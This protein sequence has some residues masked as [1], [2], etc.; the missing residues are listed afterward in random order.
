MNLAHHKALIT[1]ASK[2]LGKAIALQLAERGC[3]VTLLAR[4]EKLLRQT[5]HE[6]PLVNKTQNHQYLEYDLINLIKDDPIPELVEQ[7]EDTTI[8]VNCAGMTTH[9]LLHRLS[10]L[11]VLDTFNTNLISPVLLSQ[12]A[13]KPMLKNSK[14][15]DIKP[16]IVNISSV[17]SFTDFTS[18]GTTAYSATKAGLLGFT[19][20]LALE[21]RGRVRVNSILPGLIVETEMGQNSKLDVKPV[22]LARV[23][24]K[25]VE[26]IGDDSNGRCII[27]A[28][29]ISFYDEA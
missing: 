25:V 13:Y 15:A 22:P 28:D 16:V 7:L 8:L 4:N 27:V 23:V 24:D 18:S 1:G 10:K 5:L 29:G 12:L 26:V 21:F 9:S 20:S 6:L 3:S 19:T 14:L 2:G 11:E 17:L